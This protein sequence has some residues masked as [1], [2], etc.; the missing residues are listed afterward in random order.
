[1]SNPDDED[2][3]KA[4]RLGRY[5]KGEPRLVQYSEFQ[6]LPT[7]INAYTDSDYA[8]CIKTRKS[9]S[10]GA[11]MTRGHCITSWSSTQSAIALSSGEAEFYSLVKT[12]SQ[13]IGIKHMLSDMNIHLDINVHTDSSTATTITLRKGAGNVR[14]IGT[15]QLWIQD[16][17]K[18]QVIC[19]KNI[20][21]L[22]TPADLFTKYLSRDVI[23]THFKFLGFS[24]QTGRHNMAPLPTTFRIMMKNIQLNPSQVIV[25]AAVLRIKGKGEQRK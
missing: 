9:S 12:A 2:W 3:I 5:I 13:A 20:G 7:E 11:I 8:V 6:T 1:M 22:D 14:H 19:I 4:K 23:D 16:K 18:E 10:G 25:T 15:T 24:S 21:T 17:V